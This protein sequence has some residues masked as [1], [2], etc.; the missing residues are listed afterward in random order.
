MP[1]GHAVRDTLLRAV[2]QGDGELDLAA[3]A[4]MSAAKNV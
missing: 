3:V 2:E 4:K 1:A